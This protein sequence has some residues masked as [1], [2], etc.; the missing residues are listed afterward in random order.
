MH[1]DLF[2]KI[3]SINLFQKLN[4]NI[5]FNR[6]I[7]SSTSFSFLII[8]NLTKPSPLDPNELPGDI[9]TP[10]SRIIFLQKSKDER[11]EN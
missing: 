3:L 9:A 11:C 6:K 8:E 4:E 1:L 2:L 5:F 7:A 10:A